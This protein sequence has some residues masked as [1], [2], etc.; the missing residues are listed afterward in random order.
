MAISYTAFDSTPA[1]LVAD[2]KTNILLSTDWAN[3]TGQIV[4]ATTTRGAQMVI[5]LNDAAPDNVRAQFGVYRTHN[6]TTGTDK[7]VR[8]ITYKQGGGAS[9]EPLHCQVAAWKEG[10]FI[11]IEGPRGGEAQADDST[12]GSFKQ[13]IVLCDIVPYFGGDTIPAVA[14]I[15]HVTQNR[16][17]STGYLTVSRNQLDTGSNVP[18]RLASLSPPVAPTSSFNITSALQPV[19]KGDGNYYLWPY[20]VVEVT[21]GIR[22]RLNMLFFAGF[23]KTAVQTVAPEPNP[24]A[25][26]VVTYG[27]NTYRLVC[28]VK[29]LRGNASTNNPLGATENSSDATQYAGPII[30]VPTA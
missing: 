16:Q 1:T 6:G 15:G 11:A 18:A 25:G 3:I 20:V 27:G 29:G 14:C 21:D 2:L 19:A 5:D 9:S 10:I 23:D 17:D 30:A 8:Y 24:M 22:G 4:K 12:W 13:C 7:V 28:A 26:Q